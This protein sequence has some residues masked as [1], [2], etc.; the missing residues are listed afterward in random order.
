MCCFPR[1]RQEASPR[2]SDKKRGWAR[3]RAANDGMRR[4]GLPA[5]ATAAGSSAARARGARTRPYGR[6]GRE[7]AQN[8]APLSHGS[9]GGEA[10]ER[11]AR[12]R[13]TERERGG[14]QGGAINKRRGGSVVSKR[15]G[16]GGVA[17][18]AG[19][20]VFAAPRLHTA[21]PL[22][23]ARPRHPPPLPSRGAPGAGAPSAHRWHRWR[24]GVVGVREREEEEGV[25][26]GK[27]RRKTRNWVGSGGKCGWGPAKRPRAR[28][29]PAPPGLNGPGGEAGGGWGGDALLLLWCG[30]RRVLLLGVC[31]GKKG[32][33]LGEPADRGGGRGEGASRGC[34]RCFV[35]LKAGRIVDATAAGGRV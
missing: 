6:G 18:G 14:P 31:W 16:G 21:A 4:R 11:R 19:A 30:G 26:W 7:R 32:E 5:A 3:G 13:E 25:P 8:K 1:I 12:R 24:R 15:K 29:P 2:S 27:G 20:G 33:R 22:L 10:R 35:L 23:S 17:R 34:V 28:A 9:V